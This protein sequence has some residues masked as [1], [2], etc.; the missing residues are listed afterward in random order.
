MIFEKKNCHLS[1]LHRNEISVFRQQFILANS[2]PFSHSWHFRQSKYAHMWIHWIFVV[3][4][5][6]DKIQSFSKY[7]FLL[8][9]EVVSRPLRQCQHVQKFVCGCIELYL[10]LPAETIQKQQNRINQKCIYF[11]LKCVNSNR[12]WSFV[13]ITKCDDEIKIK[14]FADDGNLYLLNFCMMV[15]GAKCMRC[16][17]IRWIEGCRWMLSS[18]SSSLHFIPHNGIEYNAIWLCLCRR[19]EWRMNW[20]IKYCVQCSNN[21]FFSVFPLL[22]FLFC[23]YIY[24]RTDILRHILLV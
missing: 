1:F 18:S 20:W 6:E 22:S 16:N 4:D 17:A 11:D 24:Y 14:R 9:H 12:I 23:I 10:S 15:C 8:F 2:S 21:L 7:F 3:E 5:D 19:I 13:K